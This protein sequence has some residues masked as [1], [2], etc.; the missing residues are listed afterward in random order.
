MQHIDTTSI[1]INRMELRAFLTKKNQY[2]ETISGTTDYAIASE[3]FK[4]STSVTC[5]HLKPKN[6]I[7]KYV[8]I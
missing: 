3:K 5:N 2:D 6:Y 8:A 4:C 7:S 1:S